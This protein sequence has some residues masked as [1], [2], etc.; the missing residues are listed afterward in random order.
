MTLNNQSDN[1]NQ[2]NINQNLFN[3]KNM[4]FQR[5]IHKPKEVEII[6]VSSEQDTPSIDRNEMNVIKNI[7]QVKYS[8]F[9]NNNKNPFF[10]SESISEEIKNQLEGEWFVFVSDNKQNISFNISTV[11][12]T[13]FLII[14]VGNSIFRIAKIK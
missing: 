10:L 13:D 8:L 4:N 7:V 5:K 12:K 6:K 14:G 1:N 9:M 2:N 11:S 3:Y